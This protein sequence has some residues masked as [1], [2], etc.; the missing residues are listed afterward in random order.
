MT[1]F[2]EYVDPDVFEPKTSSGGCEEKGW[3]VKDTS[4]TSSEDVV[5]IVRRRLWAPL[6]APD[7]TCF[8][9]LLGIVALWLCRNCAYCGTRRTVGGMGGWMSSSPWYCHCLQPSWKEVF[10]L[11]SIF[12]FALFLRPSSTG[13]AQI[14]IELFW[15]GASPKRQPL[16]P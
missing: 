15:K 5:K 11:K 16:T 13:K 6:L 2:T 9:S 14:D 4:P 8:R 12:F 1:H 7:Q 10:S 3:W